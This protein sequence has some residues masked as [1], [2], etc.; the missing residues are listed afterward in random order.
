VTCRVG[1]WLT[2]QMGLTAPFWILLSPTHEDRGPH[3]PGMAG[4]ASSPVIVLFCPCFTGLM[5]KPTVSDSLGVLPT[6]CR[7]CAHTQSLTLN[8]DLIASQSSPVNLH[9]KALFLLPISCFL[10]LPGSPNTKRLMQCTVPA[11]TGPMLQ[12]IRTSAW[13]HRL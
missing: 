3:K 13:L 2:L 11:F 7:A 10:V 12:H 6:S 4:E 1:C 9:W 5:H 8:S